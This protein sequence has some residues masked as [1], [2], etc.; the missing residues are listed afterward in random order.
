MKKLILAIS[1][2]CISF[3]CDAHTEVIAHAGYWNCE[4]GGYTMNSEAALRASLEK[5]FWGTEFDVNM[6]ADGQL[7]VWHDQSI[8]GRNINDLQYSQ[9][10]DVT[11]RNGEK[12]PTLN[13]F[14]DIA[15]R[16]PATRLFI[17]LKFCKTREMEERLADRLL[18]VLK[19]YGLYSPD[20]VT[21]ISFSANVCRYLRKVAPEIQTQFISYNK[22]VR[23]L[24]AIGCDA[25][26]YEYNF[27]VRHPETVK[28]HPEITFNV[29][30]CDNA[31][32]IRS[33]V[34]AGVSSITTNIPEDALACIADYESR[35]AAAHAN[36]CGVSKVRDVVIYSDSSFY[37]SFPS[38]VKTRRGE[39]LVAF[40]RAPDRHIFKAW[41]TEHVDPNSNYVCVR[42]KNGV[43]WSEPEV[44]HDSPFG[45]VQDPCLLRLK[46]GT[47]LCSGFTWHYLREPSF[48]RIEKPYIRL[49]GDFVSGGGFLIRSTDNGR[50]WSPAWHQ[51]PTAV[52]MN[53]SPLGGLL[54]AYNRGAMLEGHDGRLYMAAYCSDRTLGGVTSSHLMISDDKGLTWRYS[55]P[56]AQS[57]DVAFNETSLLETP[58]GDIVAFLRTDRFGDQACIA[59]SK[60]GGNSFEWKSMGFQ[61][62]PCHALRL[63]DG[64]VLLTYG[65]R[66]SPY[67][68]RA[69]ILNPECDDYDVAE[70][71]IVRDDGI[72]G[73]LGYPWSVQIDR[74][75]VLVVYYISLDD[76]GTGIRHIEG[77]ILEI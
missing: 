47:L 51:S 25:A 56:I 10:K 19:E 73:D 59:R 58:S 29:W 61:G 48:D 45:G 52:E 40:R 70:E 65:F 15:V 63:K 33:L 23:K 24:N 17:E 68:I 16:Y 75:H 11:L 39:L 74:H 36:S 20:R 69:R 46:D 6:T 34:R 26:D 53:H 13:Q 66:H 18:A 43:D 77:T 32:A 35:S 4:R 55:C 64:R 1:A 7:V 28:A 21:F 37:S 14:L 72:C 27:I 76:P 67:G 49:L 71:I 8:D 9:I 44:F 42:S 3:M 57:Q 54:P 30:T 31:D 12:L 38:V 5:G 60:D 50:S 41:A 2:I 22:D 62:H